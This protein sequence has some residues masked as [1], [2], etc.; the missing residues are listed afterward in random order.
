M[1]IRDRVWTDSDDKGGT[2][3]DS[4]RLVLCANGEEYREAT[5]ERPDTDDGR[6]AYTFEGLPEYDEMCIRDRP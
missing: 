3:P 5:V 1:C 6:W 2:R 4:I